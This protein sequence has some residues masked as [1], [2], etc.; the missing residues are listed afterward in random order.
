MSK[1]Q[2]V[3]VIARMP[4]LPLVRQETKTESKQDPAEPRPST[5]QEQI[6]ILEEPRVTQ[7]PA[8][9]MEEETV[10]KEEDKPE[11][12]VTDEYFRKK[13]FDWER[14]GSQSEN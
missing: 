4:I 8:E 10:E 3:S 11:V 7:D 6:A 5:T 1:T 9:V 13:H 14:E 2:A 12:G